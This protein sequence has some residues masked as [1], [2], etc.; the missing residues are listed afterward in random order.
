MPKSTA[1]FDTTSILIDEALDRLESTYA[2][3]F[4]GINPDY[5]NLIRSAGT[6]A[7]EI[8]A[9]SDALY[10]NVEHSIMVAMVGQE[11]L[12][13]KYLSEGSVT[14]REW[15]HFIVSLLCHDIGYVKGIC[16]G[17]TATVA[18][19]NAQGETVALPAGCTGAFLTPY[20]VERGKL[21]VFNRF[22]DHP[23]ISAKVI[24]RNIEHTRFPVPEE[25]DSP[26]DSDFPGLVR[27]AD[28]IGQLADPNYLQKLPALFHEFAETGAN[29]SI[30]YETPD[31][32][33]ENYPN[34]YWKFV[35]PHVR[36][37]V[38]Y[39]RVTREGRQWEAGLYS[40]IFSEEH[41]QLAQRR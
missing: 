37:A 7:M 9:N 23:V 32:V 33:R 41:R 19:I 25:G 24:A 12:R 36:P 39:L 15:V 28:L 30:G 34:F 35:S 5:P 4:G 38:E 21:F 14:A 20:H 13:G 3:V 27:S 11:I 16:P 2:R 8:I 22:K 17:D 18:V 10:H 40:H 26:D 1:A 6:M 31:D 29:K